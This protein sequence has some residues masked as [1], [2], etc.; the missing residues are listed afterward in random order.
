LVIKIG[1]SIEC[2]AVAFENYGMLK[3]VLKGLNIKIEEK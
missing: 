2:K 1:F 3:K